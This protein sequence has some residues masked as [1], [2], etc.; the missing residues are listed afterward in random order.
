MHAKAMAFSAAAGWDAA[1]GM[2][3]PNQPARRVMRGH[4]S[5][6]CDQARFKFGKECDHPLAPQMSSESNF[7]LL[8]DA[9]NLKDILGQMDGDHMNLHVFASFEQIALQH[10]P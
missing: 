1:N 3:E 9:V 6:Y 10:S 7:E 2:A 5:L 8:V 4:A